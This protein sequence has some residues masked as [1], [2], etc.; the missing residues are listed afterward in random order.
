MGCLIPT[1]AETVGDCLESQTRVVRYCE[2]CRRSPKVDLL[3]MARQEGPF[4]WLWDRRTPCPHCGL[5]LSYLFSSGAGTP[6]R[7]MISTWVHD[8]DLSRRMRS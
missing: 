7:P 2:R 1:Y 8:V 5:M 6:V 3:E 4:Y